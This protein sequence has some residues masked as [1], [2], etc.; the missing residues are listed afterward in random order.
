MRTKGTSRSLRRGGFTLVELMFTS[1][2]SL[3]VVG[4][5]IALLV[6]TLSYWNDVGLRMDAD[7]D[8]NIALSR[9]VYGMDGRTGLRTAGGNSVKIVPGAGGAWTLSYSTGGASPKNHSFVYSP[10]QR[11]LISNPGSKLAGRDIKTAQVVRQGSSVFVTLCVEKKKG[12]VVA[13]REIATR[14]AFRNQ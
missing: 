4:G 12:K 5:V 11:T 1:A 7:S 8:A 3:L 13:S 10:V 14:I 2:I 6:S 9:M